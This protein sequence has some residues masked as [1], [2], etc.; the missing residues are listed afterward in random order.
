MENERKTYLNWKKN[1]PFQKSEVHAEYAE[2]RQTAGERERE[3][4]RES[5]GSNCDM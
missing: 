2:C 4:E 5:P 1:E 3:R